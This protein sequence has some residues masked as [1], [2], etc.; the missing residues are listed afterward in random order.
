Q[1]VVGSLYDGDCETEKRLDQGLR[2]LI[3]LCS[4]GILTASNFCMQLQAAPTRGEID[5][6][7]REGQWLDIG[8]PS[9]RNWRYIGRWRQVTWALP[10]MS[11]LPIHLM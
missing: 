6:A 2:L 7:H 1:N 10:A 9:L 3:N 4:T 8:V 11:S 5:S